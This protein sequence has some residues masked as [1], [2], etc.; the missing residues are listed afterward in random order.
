MQDFT[1]YSYTIRLD[2]LEQTVK[3]AMRGGYRVT[4]IINGEYYD[5]NMDKAEKAGKGRGKE[6]GSDI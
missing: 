3:E 1:E 6:N 5:I 2:R 4:V